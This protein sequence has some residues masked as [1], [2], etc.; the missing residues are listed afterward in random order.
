MRKF[1]IPLFLLLFFTVFANAQKNMSERE[2]APVSVES[3]YGAQT[4]LLGIWV[5]RETKLSHEFAL[6]TEIGLTASLVI[7]LYE[8]TLFGLRPSV[9]LEPRWYYNLDKRAE[10]G[11]R[12]ANN[13]GNFIAMRLG[14]ISNLFT[15]SNYDK[16]EF[17]N[18]IFTFL[19]WGIRR[20]LG[21]QFN[22]EAGAGIGAGYISENNIGLEDDE[23]FE[24]SPSIYLRIGYTF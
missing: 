14:Y 13:S 15:I 19:H 24:F 1:Y 22:F 7:G 8:E 4:G 11:K 9:A 3:F 21:K 10:K 18:T 16:A 2:K 6:R 17:S 20:N 12:I 23:G 5:H